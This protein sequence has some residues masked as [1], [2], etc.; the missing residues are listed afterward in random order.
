[1]FCIGIFSRPEIGVRFKKWRNLRA[2]N[3]LNPPYTLNQVAGS[4]VS[5]HWHAALAKT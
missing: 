5:G 1:M 3:A 4:A 2:G